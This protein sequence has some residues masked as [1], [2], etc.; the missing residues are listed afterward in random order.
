M[1]NIVILK[2]GT[3]WGGM[4][5]WVFE[6]S[7]ELVKRGHNVVVVCHPQSKLYLNCVKNDIGVK[8]LIIEKS[9]SLNIF[10]I[11]GFYRYLKKNKVDAIIV[12]SSA[13][14]KFG[15]L[16]ARLAG[17]KKI[18]HRQGGDLKIRN[19]F[20]NRLLLGKYAT[21]IIANSIATRDTML[22][23]NETWLK[24]DM[25]KV[26]YNGV[27]VEKYSNPEIVTN[28]REE[29]Q[30]PAEKVLMVKIGRLD[31]QKG[32]EYLIESI[33]KVKQHFQNFHLLIVGTGPL[34]SELKNKVK[35]LGLEE[36]IT[37]TGFREDIPSILAQ[38]DF[39]V[40]TALWEGF[41]FVLAE[42]MAAKKPIV[43]MDASNI[44]ELVIDGVNGYLAKYKD[45][46]DI[47][48]KIIKMCCTDEREMIGERGF[49]IVKEKYSFERMV[50][51]V[52]KLISK[53]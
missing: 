28:I 47:A 36:Y 25:I 51:E 3:I 18:I 50:D 22:K 44:S 31:I 41:G 7:Q 37:F 21:N 12:G 49:E 16:A 27:K 34:E 8:G 45:T 1:S 42:A 52:E 39:L 5:H 32:H 23:G 26:I 17:V 19:T 48:V 29:F 9:S 4:E 43:A 10:K 6:T 24:K 53:N 13:D 46:D 35:E 38:V 14:R 20:Y 30:I 2:N 33:N 11:I 15:I 40:H